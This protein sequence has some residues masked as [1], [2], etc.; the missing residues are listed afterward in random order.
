MTPGSSGADDL[1][2]L[3]L[4]GGD[5]VAHGPGAGPFEG[6]QQRAGAAELELAVARRRRGPGRPSPAPTAVPTRAPW[7]LAGVRRAVHAW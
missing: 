7:R 3:A 6:G 2:L 1:V 5:D 4:D